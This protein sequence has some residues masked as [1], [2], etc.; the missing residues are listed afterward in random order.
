MKFGSSGIRGLAPG[1]ITPDL[2]LRFGMAVGA[3]H[4]SVV[5]GRDTRTSSPT[6]AN[7]VV[8][9]ALS[10][11]ARVADAGMLPTPTLAHA[12]RRYDAGVMVTASHNPPEYNG[13]KLW[14]APGRAANAAER[15]AVE[16]LLKTPPSGM[17]WN[18]LH[19]V[20]RETRAEREHADAILGQ[21]KLERRVRVV[22]DCANGAGCDASPRLL[23]RLG[24]DVVT[25]HAQPDG[26]FP[27]RPPEPTAETLTDLCK[28]VKAT[29]A[30]AGIA[31]DGDADRAV[32]VTEKGVVVSG[33]ALLALLAARL[34]A[35]KPVVPLDTSMAVDDALKGA[36]VTR[37]RV[38]DAFI[39]EELARSGGDFGGEPSGAFIFPKI[40]LCPDGLHA[41][42]YI[43]AMASDA[44]LSELV[45]RLPRY[46]LVRASL[47]VAAGRVGNA[48]A[49]IAK[50]LRSWGPVEEL[51]GVRVSVKDGW[52]LVRPSGTEPKF[53][54]TSE[55]RDE[56]T[57]QAN[58]ELALDV[59]KKAVNG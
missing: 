57:A 47:P 16:A 52:V 50:E 19:G 17:P 59:V 4:K 42:A 54:V 45:A 9:G 37:T 35:R 20:E 46:P 56:K 12:T 5:V 10:G 26:T 11:G 22:V 3:L 13:L 40:S 7:A 28:A 58:L 36:R 51:D 49:A 34:K 48:M 23:R 1:E 41:A 31:H 24:C 27:G 53:R 30:H 8:S 25:L 15:T 33:D 44:K 2:A 21:V 43:A 32:A 55:A 29:G 18:V 14:I 6:L 38:G 39:S